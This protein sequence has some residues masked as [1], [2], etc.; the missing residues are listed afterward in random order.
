MTHLPATNSRPSISPRAPEPLNQAL[1]CSLAK[2]LSALDDGSLSV[3]TLPSGPRVALRSRREQLRAALA[4]AGADLTAKILAT[5][6]G[7]PMRTEASRDAARAL[8]LQDVHDL[9]DLPWFALDGA[10]RAY[11]LKERGEGW[12]PTA[13]DLRQ[14]AIRRVEPHARELAKIGRVLDSPLLDKPAP[15][16]ASAEQREEI[17]ARFAE[18]SARMGA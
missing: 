15:R 3:D 12:H 14:E 1:D 17:K 7:M 9:S 8:A 4:P 13:G 18:L 10:A 2:A 16:R 6:A 5:L 11:R